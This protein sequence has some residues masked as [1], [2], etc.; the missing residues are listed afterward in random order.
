MKEKIH[1]LNHWLDLKGEK[2]RKREIEI[3]TTLVGSGIF[4]FFSLT[5]LIITPGQVEIGS[6]DVV[7]GRNFPMLLMGLSALCCA[8]LIFSEIY[9]I[10]KKIPL[11]KKKIN[12]L[13][14]V[15]ALIIFLIMLMFFL[16]AKTVGFGIGAVLCTVLILL[17]FRSANIKY[18]IIT[19]LF[20]VAVWAAFR[21]GLNVRF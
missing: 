5:V 6:K 9:K 19:A 7:N 10:I 1:V 17:F 11:E 20:A 18:Y 14:E 21:F 15:K 4:L 13:V 3:P 8:V 2:L 16:A 12:L